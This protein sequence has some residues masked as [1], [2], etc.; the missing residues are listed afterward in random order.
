V[1]QHQAVVKQHSEKPYDKGDAKE[2]RGGCA[3]EG[4][5]KHSNDSVQHGQSKV[6]KNPLEQPAPIFRGAL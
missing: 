3:E 1:K 2:K 4:Y 5:K 6:K